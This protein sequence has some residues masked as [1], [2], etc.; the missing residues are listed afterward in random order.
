MKIFF[1]SILF[2]ISTFVKAQIF[3]DF[4][5]KQQLGFYENK[6]SKAYTALTTLKNFILKKQKKFYVENTNNDYY[7]EFYKIF[8][9]P[10]VPQKYYSYI[11][12]TY[13]I[14]NNIIIFEVDVIECF[15]MN[16]EM[17]NTVYV[18]AYIL[19]DLNKN[20]IL[21]ADNN[22]NLLPNIKINHFNNISLIS[23]HVDINKKDISKIKRYIN[24]Q[25]KALYIDKNALNKQN[26]TI[27]S[28]NTLNDGYFYYGINKYIAYTNNHRNY[29][30]FAGKN[31]VFYQH[32]IIHYLLNLKAEKINP[33]IDEG[34][35][36]WLG[37]STTNSYEEFIIKSTDGLSDSQ[38]ALIISKFISDS[39]AK[40]NNDYDYYIR[41]L[42]VNAIFDS[43]ELIDKNLLNKLI[44]KNLY[45]HSVK[46][47]IYETGLSRT[48]IR[49]KMI[50][51]INQIKGSNK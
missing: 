43:Q 16:K 21:L 7:K 49:S 46:Q 13:S 39:N 12:T 19:I 24:H 37:G 48:Q 4:Y 20:K 38:I 28:S 10:N 26:L 8:F 51:R 44:N 3:N 30:I 25:S 15:E 9:N 2:L 40:N 11:P 34:L 17:N 14:K 29:K 5:I 27:I 1:Y 23:N 33:I 50:N 42:F 22:I 18:N 41:A 36:T 6:N 31:S 32:E 47:L 45:N 35:A